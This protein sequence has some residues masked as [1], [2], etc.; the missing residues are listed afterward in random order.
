M[1]SEGVI[2]DRMHAYHMARADGGVGL[3]VVQVSQVDPTEGDDGGMLHAFDDVVIPGYA[4]LATEAHQRGTKVFAQLHHGGREA[5]R[6]G[7][8]TLPVPVG[9]S[10]IPNERFLMMPRELS[11]GRI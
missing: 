1:I 10:S 5:H 6:H 2:N 11:V 4:R 9:P 3:I 8:G 7:D